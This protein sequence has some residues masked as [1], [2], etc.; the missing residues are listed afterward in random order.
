MRV[1]YLVFLV[2]FVS[3]ACASGTE[4]GKKGPKVT[5]KVSVTLLQLCSWHLRTPVIP[6]LI[7]VFCC[8]LVNYYFFKG[9]VRCYNWG[10]GE[11]E[12]RNRIVW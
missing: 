9:L 11:A 12:N 8:M 6:K 7:P 4:T 3:A 5:D 2:V 1:H 10:R